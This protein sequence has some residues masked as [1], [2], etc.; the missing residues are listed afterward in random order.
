MLAYHVISD[1]AVG[2]AAVLLSGL[3]PALEA[4]G[5]CSA[6]LLPEESNLIPYFKNAS[7]PL[8]FLKNSGRFLPVRQVLSL[9]RQFKHAPPHVVVSHGSLSAKIAARLCSLPCAS[10]KH[11]DLPV[12]G[13]WLYRLLT[14]ATV[15]TS[16]PCAHHLREQ[17]LSAVYCIE[18]GFS[19]IAVPTARERQAARAALSLD[20][21]AI[22]VGL[23]GRL[24]AVKGQETAIRALSLLGDGGRRICLLLLGEGE[25]EPR[26]R[27]LCHALAIEERV[28]FLG[29]RNDP[30][31]FYHALDIHLSCSLYSETSS[32]SLAEGMSAALPTVASDTAGNR[33]RVADG[34]LL[35][36]AGN[37][38]ALSERLRFLMDERVRLHLQKAA[39]SRAARLP[40]HAD[41]AKDYASLFSALCAK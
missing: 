9:C 7:I 6:V 15:A 10:V 27:A 14:D 26:L 25:D 17:G 12:K 33:L 1:E 13:R 8:H 20:E 4:R 38:E 5:V 11:C 19:P 24:S 30:T 23:C 29:F 39:L 16:L 40:R 36:P 41:A 3:V 37:A 22:A 28:T 34:G 21:D 35:Y 32:L 18:N 31:D 2:G